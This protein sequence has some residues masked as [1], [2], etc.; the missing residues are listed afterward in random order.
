M[1][2]E[3]EQLRVCRASIGDFR[4]GLDQLRAKFAILTAQLENG[5]LAGAHETFVDLQVS[6]S[7]ANASWGELVKV[8]DLCIPPQSP[9]ASDA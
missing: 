1:L 8:I 4:D 6:M 7:E 5:N 9:S 2:A 3:D